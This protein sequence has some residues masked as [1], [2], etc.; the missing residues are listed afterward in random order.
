MRFF[1]AIY[2][3]VLILAV[4]LMLYALLVSFKTPRRG[5][6]SYQ[7]ERERQIELDREFYRR[8]PDAWGRL[9]EKINDS[10]WRGEEEMRR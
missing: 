4:L 2:N 1:N 7:R 8:N 5:D 9:H 10:G 6:S 3:L